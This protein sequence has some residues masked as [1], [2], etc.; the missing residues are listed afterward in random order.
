MKE[1]KI[2]QQARQNLQSDAAD[3]TSWIKPIL[4]MIEYKQTDSES[5]DFVPLNK[6]I[7]LEHILPRQYKTIS[8]WDHI[9]KD[10]ADKYINSIGNLTLLKGKKNIT[11]SNKPFKNKLRIYRGK[12]KDKGITSLLITQQIARDANEGKIEN[13][14][15]KAIEKRRNWLLSELE[16]LLLYGFSKKPSTIEDIKKRY[17]DKKST[18]QKNKEIA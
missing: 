4:M 14:D 13:W 11:A 17:S 1:D 2:F 18:S 10:T 3:K 15:K 12:G 9:E 6:G 16:D 8:K 5:Q 7:H